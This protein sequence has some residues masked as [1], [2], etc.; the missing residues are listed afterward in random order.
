MDENPAM[1]YEL[2]VIKEA[3]ISTAYVQNGK[4]SFYLS[5]KTVVP[6]SK[7]RIGENNSI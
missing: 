6:S 3:N 5:L 7:K 4:D 2:K 1:L